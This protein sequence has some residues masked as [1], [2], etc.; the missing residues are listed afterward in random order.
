MYFLAMGWIIWGSNPIKA[1][2][3]LSLPNWRGTIHIS[4]ATKETP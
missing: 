1:K 4:D 2:R 3:L